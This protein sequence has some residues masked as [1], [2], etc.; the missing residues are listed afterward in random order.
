MGVGKRTE[1]KIFLK[2]LFSIV[3]TFFT[4]IQSYV[5]SEECKKDE[6]HIYD[7]SIY[8]EM[9]LGI[10]SN[11]MKRVTGDR[12]FENIF[13]RIKLFL[14]RCFM[15]I[16]VFDLHKRPP[17]KTIDTTRS[18]K[19]DARE[20]KPINDK[21]FPQFVDPRNK[22]LKTVQTKL[23]KMLKNQRSI[24][25]LAER[26]AYKKIADNL[27]KQIKKIEDEIEKRPIDVWK[28][29]KAVEK[30]RLN[31]YGYY[32][33]KF[34]IRLKK[35]PLPPNHTLLFDGAVVY[36]HNRFTCV[37]FYTNSKYEIRAKIGF[38]S[39]C[40]EGEQAIMSHI[41][42][43]MLQSKPNEVKKKKVVVHSTD[44]DFY[45]MLLLFHAL[46]VEKRGNMDLYLL[47]KNFYCGKR[48]EKKYP[49]TWKC[50]AYTV[51]V[52]KMAE[53]IRE[54][55]SVSCK[56]PIITFAVW[57]GIFLGCDF[58][59]DVHKT[60][61]KPNQK[62]QTTYDFLKFW[63]KDSLKTQNDA[64]LV[65]K[66]RDVCYAEDTRF[67]I[68]I[69]KEFVFTEM[70]RY[71]KSKKYRMSKADKVKLLMICLNT[72]YIAH[73]MVNQYRRK[74]KRDEIIPPCDMEDSDGQKIYGYE[75]MDGK[76]VQSKK[77]PK[78]FTKFIL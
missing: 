29:G 32:T 22:K 40:V 56:H 42:R 62:P 60:F 59:A 65:K 21:H 46:H 27:K 37:E 7:G 72:D 6:I 31:L 48:Y 38:K 34:E 49:K 63:F 53:L 33:K 28:E 8:H 43:I 52:S 13:N 66:V 39:D 76:I 64:I 67:I 41:Y 12:V 74:E 36:P 75:Y 16:F 54:E 45:T 4:S 1:K 5:S 55:Y 18:Y 24:F 14:N 51:H 50:K 68:R 10:C 69:N 70:K 71:L 3:F 26:V 58:I 20:F 61:Q 73:Y 2:T 77:F 9:E 11:F 25:T 30:N 78:K 15:N 19:D 57:W 44:T 47:T 35:T 23:K 17:F